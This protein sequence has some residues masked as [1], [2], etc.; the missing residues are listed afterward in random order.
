[1][2][3]YKEL[4]LWNPKT[5][6]ETFVNLNNA[7]DTAKRIALVY[8]RETVITLDTIEGQEIISSVKVVIIRPS[9]FNLDGTIK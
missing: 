7:I 2:K 9:K 5:M 8:R 4:R 1:M 6:P 3:T